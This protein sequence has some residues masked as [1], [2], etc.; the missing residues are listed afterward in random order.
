MIR[1]IAPVAIAF[2]M[3]ACDATPAE[4]TA[5]A[6]LMA[7]QGNSVTGQVQFTQQGNKVLVAG[8]VRGLQ[9][10]TEHGFHV[11]ERGD[12]SSGDGLMRVAISTPTAKRTARMIRASTTPVTCPV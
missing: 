7:T 8:A 5:S 3:T 1:L 12:C 4:A 2:F 9:A 10:N 11:H 6:Q